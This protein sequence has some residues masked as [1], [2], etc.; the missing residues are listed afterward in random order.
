MSA[1]PDATFLA[2]IVRS[3]DDAIIS[4]NLDGLIV[5]WNGAAERLFGY[6]AADVIGQPIS[7]LA[8]NPN[9]SE[10]PD[11]L[12]RI[13][14]GERV[15][16]YETE[17]RCRDG[18]LVHI[19]LSAS[20]IWDGSG[21]LI[22]VSTI[23]RDI[24]ARKTEQA[25]RNMQRAILETVAQHAPLSGILT[26]ICLTAEF[27]IPG[28][29]CFVMR[30]NPDTSLLTVAAAPNLP[31]WYIDVLQD[32]LPIAPQTGTCGAAA[33]LRQP[34]ITPD[35]DTDPA[36]SARKQWPQRAGY[37]S[38]WSFP[39]LADDGELYGTFAAYCIQSR[40]PTVQEA[41]ALR[42]L[43]H[44]ARIAVRRAH[45][46]AALGA[47]ESRFRA[48]FQV[49]AAGLATC[50]TNGRFLSVNPKM[51]EI[52]GYPEAELIGKTYLEVTHPEDREANQK[53]IRDLFAGDSSPIA[54]EKRYL[55]KDGSVVWVRA[56][57]SVVPDDGGRPLQSIA[58]VEDITARRQAEEQARESEA[59]YR[60]LSEAIPQFVWMAG[61]DGNLS[62][63]NQ[64]W[65]TYT[66][67]TWEQTVERGWT[68][69]V[70]PEDQ[71]RVVAEALR[72]AQLGLP[73]DT[74]Y[75]LLRQD[76][77]YRWHLARANRFA[78]ADGRHRWLGTAIDIEE[79]KLSE[80]ALK[81]ERERL[82]LALD[83]A[84]MG[85]WEWDIRS[86]QVTWS[87]ELRLASGLN[88]ADFSGTY[89]SAMGTVHP[90]DYDRVQQAVDRSLNDNAP[91]DVE[92]RT[93]PIGGS[94]RWIQG[95][96]HLIRDVNGAPAKLMGVAMDITSRKLAEAEAART[97]NLLER[98]LSSI[99][100]SF[101]SFDRQWRFLYVNDRVL[102]RSGYTREQL[103]GNVVWDLF[104]NTRDTLLW[105]EYHRVM[106]ERI[107]RLFEVSDPR[108]GSGQ[109]FEVRA[110]PTE[111]GMCAYVMNVTDRKRS[112]DALK[113]R[114]EFYRTLG[115][116]VPDFI[117]LTGPDGNILY[118]NRGWQE[119]TGRALP[120][121]NH[122]AWHWFCHPEDVES[123]RQKWRE[124][125]QSGSRFE[126]EFRYRRQDG[127]YCWFMA[128]AV[129]IRDAVTGD[130]SQW[131][132]TST[133]IHKL[134]EAEE[135]LRRYNVQL[136]EFAFAAAHDLQEPLRN[137]SIFS[138][139]LVRR[140]GD[141]LQGQDR[142]FLLLVRAGALRM[143]A[144]VRDLLLYTRVL[145]TQS[146]SACG[147]S[148]AAI[149]DVREALSERLAAANAKLAYQ[150]LPVV[151]VPHP[152]LVQ[153][154]QNLISN[155]IKYRDPERSPEIR[156]TASSE[157]AGWHFS[158]A[159]NGI[160]IHPD[161]HQRVFGLFKRLHGQEIAGT[162]IGLTIVKRIVE[163][164]GGKI[165]LESEPGQ[166]TTFHFTLP[167]VNEEE[168][169]PD[170]S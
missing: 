68:S 15:E 130:V 154:F 139:M 140:L 103:L 166:G 24:T 105:T 31:S 4:K 6:P 19:S 108:L 69:T 94:I 95:K 158:V 81:V 168:P 34:V 78:L 143:S 1:P 157:R 53:A 2:A 127:R 102:E 146:G 76:G 29:T 35:I 9:S 150:N 42:D 25:A 18:R 46:E 98:T 67:L 63:V 55:R 129:P 38:C 30:A 137:V 82:Q 26:S 74:E 66:G 165:W 45:H 61:D 160:G 97:A 96:G 163:H 167:A 162:G 133:E 87:H 156:I 56:T 86:G 114:E 159:D 36:W 43:L 41:E 60:F 27:Q 101:L 92:Y 89:H 32:G 14:Q 85:T 71:P 122:L 117:W 73:F 37:R 107:P 91:Y 50:D 106:E 144:L 33:Y 152:H 111:E 28:T 62:Y 164:Y 99:S 118:A 47:S 104:P 115:E 21:E 49:A 151:P 51:V 116:A 58:I 8:A 141:R 7:M 39:I 17:R 11:I 135:T 75:R 80:S 138:E 169:T 12:S 10:M 142:E 44:L 93:Q 136:E 3:S 109:T 100:E 59:R 22:G 48:V 5:T 123:I 120:D 83:A 131:V 20:P 149:H 145:D 90:D 155:A 88:P 54:I 77:Q 65:H 132:G 128:R 64:H 110:Y 84:R 16:H 124:A 72:S 52:T 134:K 70:H 148:A 121:L 126:A 170:R 113:E 119:Y 153:I 79:R 125:L 57:V 161:Y 40:V 23:A 147:D 13:R 112:E